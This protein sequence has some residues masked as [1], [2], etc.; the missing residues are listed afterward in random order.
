MAATAEGNF[1]NN[2][3]TTPNHGF[4]LGDKE[5]A[6]DCSTGKEEQT[7]QAAL[8]I[9]GGV[10]MGEY[11]QPRQATPVHEHAEQHGGAQ[12]PRTCRTAGK[13]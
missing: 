5:K 12:R 7:A 9:N 11:R 2:Q 10:W 4:L 3:K 13:T 8:P 1:K 6:A